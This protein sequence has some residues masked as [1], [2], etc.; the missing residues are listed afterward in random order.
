MLDH[1]ADA[2][3]NGT[4]NHGTYQGACSY[5]DYPLRRLPPAGHRAEHRASKVAVTA[6]AL[7]LLSA[8]LRSFAAIASFGSSREEAGR[9]TASHTEKKMH[10]EI[11]K[12]VFGIVTRNG[13]NQWTQ[14]G[15]AFGTR[16]NSWNIR[17][18]YI[19]ASLATTT[20]QLRDI[21][22]RRKSESSDAVACL[23]SV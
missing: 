1:V 2:L 23:E 7:G 20:I 5:S 18:D 16:D 22:P 8:A 3:R 10:S 14:I 12:A 19:P 17:L 6:F 15:V 13:R 11:M 4:C 21:E 9:W